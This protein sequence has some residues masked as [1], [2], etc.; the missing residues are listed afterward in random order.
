MGDATA[1]GLATNRNWL[2]GRLA[3]DLPPSTREL[4]FDRPD[5]PEEARPF[6]ERCLKRPAAERWATAGEMQALRRRCAALAGDGHLELYKSTVKYDGDV[7]REQHGHPPSK[8]MPIETG[9]VQ[10]LRTA[11]PM[12]RLRPST[13]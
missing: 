12:N 8:Q 10:L 5:V 3:N 7:G 4:R 1:A 6:L 11:W 9:P 13:L 2:T